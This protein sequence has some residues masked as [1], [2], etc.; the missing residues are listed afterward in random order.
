MKSLESS[1]KIR[2]IKISNFKTYF[3]IQF[4]YNTELFISKKLYQKNYIKK[5]NK[6]SKICKSESSFLL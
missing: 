6:N 2:E 3:F 1:N 5:I 4:H